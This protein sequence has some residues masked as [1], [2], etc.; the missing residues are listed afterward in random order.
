MERK[1][2]LDLA[3]DFLKASTNPIDK[4]SRAFYS[5]LYYPLKKWSPSYPETTGY[6]IP[7]FLDL[8]NLDKEYDWCAERAVEM[9]DWLV[10]IQA[11]DGAFP[12]N[13]WRGRFEEGSIFNTAQIIKGLI[14]M[15]DYTKEEKYHESFVNA[16]KWIVKCQEP[17]GSW[18]K[19]AYQ[20]DFFPSYY[21]RVAYPVL[22]AGNEINDSKIKE[23]A[24]KTLKAIVRKRKKNGAIADWGFKPDSY[25]FSH[26]IAYT[27]RGF[28]EGYNLSGEKQYLQMAQDL[29]EKFLR[30]FEIK[31]YLAGA[32]YE[33][34]TE[35]KWY[36]CLTGEAQMS[37]IWLKLFDI[38][39][40][41]RYLNGAS[42]LLDQMAG[43]QTIRNGLLVKKGGFTGSKPIW[44]RYIA[45][46]QPN[47]A[48][49]FFI[50]ALILEEKAYK[51]LDKKIGL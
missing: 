46:R 39:D 18:K 50:D 9:A 21:T 43:A 33:D 42:K 5:P 24:H 48:A 27:I 17:D 29:G 16:A 35:I 25:A 6:I 20:S 22:W 45:F 49:K 41:V 2:N 40:D 36:R 51:K 23:A 28:L 13:L 8:H 34:Y 47:W 19:F 14:R 37:I 7:T 11:K 32:Y 12:G 15:Y 31:K 4:G 38:T 1:I 44:G 3:V 10:S 26:T 30:L